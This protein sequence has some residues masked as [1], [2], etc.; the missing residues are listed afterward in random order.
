MWVQSIY[1]SSFSSIASLTTAIYYRKRIAGNT[2]THT[3]THIQNGSDT[4]P[5]LDIGS[6]KEFEWFQVTING[7]LK[8]ISSGVNVVIGV[9]T[10]NEIW[11]RYKISASEPTGTEIKAV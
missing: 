1:A 10:R 5:I 4:L 2:Q 9:N 11:R 8:Q 7:R 3:H 6:S